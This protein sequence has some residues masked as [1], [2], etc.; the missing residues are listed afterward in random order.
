MTVNCWP[1]PRTCPFL[2]AHQLHIAAPQRNKIYRSGVFRIYSRNATRP[3]R[4]SIASH[5]RTVRLRKSTPRE[6]SN[7][8]QGSTEEGR[9]RW[10]ISQ[11]SVGVEDMHEDK[12]VRRLLFYCWG[13][14][15]L[16]SWC[17]ICT[18]SIDDLGHFLALAPG[19]MKMLRKTKRY[20][21][22]HICEP[23]NGWQNPTHLPAVIAKCDKKQSKNIT[24]AAHGIVGVRGVTRAAK[25]LHQIYIFEVEA[26]FSSK[27]INSSH[28]RFRNKTPNFQYHVYI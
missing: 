2:S 26:N 1:L 7:H 25:S 23:V 17:I 11:S 18:F 6:C 9:H 14:G 4:T 8:T 22:L 24:A 16:L 21:A 15:V 19:D 13:G 5:W 20:S 12:H 27:E 3:Q 28:L 10:T